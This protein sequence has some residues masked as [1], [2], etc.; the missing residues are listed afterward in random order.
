MTDSE[1]IALYDA[2]LNMTLT[3]LSRITGKSIK[4]LKLILLGG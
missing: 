1:I 3:E 4:Q 2:N